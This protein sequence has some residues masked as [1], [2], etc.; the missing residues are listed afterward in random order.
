[1]CPARV[2]LPNLTRVGMRQ[3]KPVHRAKQG[4]ALLAQ[5]KPAYESIDFVH[6]DE[7]TD[8]TTQFDPT[9]AHGHKNR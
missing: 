7:G 1:V 4:V 9:L 2:A 3:N 6:A 5:P 8:R